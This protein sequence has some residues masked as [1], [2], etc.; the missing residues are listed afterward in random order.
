[1]NRTR[2]LL[3][4]F[5]ALGTLLAAPAHGGTRV[6]V[7][8]G[9]ATVEGEPLATFVRPV[10]ST[11]GSVAFAGATGALLVKDAA[12]FT[13]LARTGDALPAPLVGT[14]NA[15]GG[16]AINAAG[17]VAFRATLNSTAADQGIFLYRDGAFVTV[18]LGGG[19]GGD[20]DGVGDPELNAALDVAYENRGGLRLWSAATGL[21]VRLADRSDAAPSGGTF[22]RFGRQPS[23]NDAGT[24]AFFAEVRKGT[25]GV[26][27]VPRG[28]PLV[29]VAA[30][31]RL[32]ARRVSLSI[33]GGGQ[34]AFTDGR[35]RTVLLYDPATGGVTTVV[36]TGV[37]VGAE[38]RLRFVREDAVGLDDQGRVFF[39]GR[40]QRSG[41][42]GD[43][44]LLASAGSVTALSDGV[45]GRVA[46]RSSAGGRIVWTVAGELF[47]YD[48]AAVRLV[49]RGDPTPLGP[50]LI[51]EGPSV[52]D[53]GTVAFAAAR[54]ALYVLSGETVRTVLRG[55][56]DIA[57]AGMVTAFGAHAF[58]GERIACLVT[59]DDGRRA[60]LAGPPGGLV[61]VA[62]TGTPTSDGTLALDADVIGIDGQRL[63]FGTAV[64]GANGKATNSLVQ[65][66][67]RN[68]SL[69][70]RALPGGRLTRNGVFLPFA[71]VS[72]MP[73]R[74]GVTGAT[75][76]S[77]EILV[78][79]G[80]DGAARA[81]A[82]GARAPHT[83]G[84]FGSFGAPVVGARLALFAATVVGGRT[85]GGIF[86]WGHRRAKPIV[87]EGEAAPGG[88]TIGAIDEASVPLALDGH[89]AVF[90]IPVVVDGVERAALFVTTGLVPRLVAREGDP[91]PVGTIGAFGAPGSLAIAGERIVCASPLSGSGA[92]AGLFACDD[93]RCD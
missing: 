82:E 87:L 14:F 38:G 32:V 24:V 5:V 11:G 3:G 20:P 36:K 50:G 18:A 51:A 48:G 57:G 61:A 81:A 64:I 27:V 8:S 31:K 34:I 70:V 86:L 85:D 91:T 25:S 90:A 72:V 67:L 60:V 46:V 10:P 58:D 17:A 35:R 42:D 29:R 12:G 26:F 66:S 93:L 37:A 75:R 53:A 41:P 16:T 68:Q 56:D 23:L 15:F 22:R 39:S 21:V 19:S 83:G 49:G 33:N 77:D 52:N 54:E 47:G 65:V 80:A 69:R 44:A 28:G 78:V 62:V 76:R 45:S 1:M 63:V 4:A 84:K 9:D 92:A 13:V 71:P 79:A 43:Q 2:L 55:G 88:G 30:T 74:V 73:P 89:H 40:V 6:L 7:R 59:L